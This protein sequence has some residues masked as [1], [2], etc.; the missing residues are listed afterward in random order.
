MGTS[1]WLQN[2]PLKA[3][4][5]M[6]DDA[7]KIYEPVGVEETHGNRGDSVKRYTLMKS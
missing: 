3:R 7:G 1:I 6:A 2:A 5:A 4:A